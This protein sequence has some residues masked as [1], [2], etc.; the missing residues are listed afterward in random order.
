MGTILD[1]RIEFASTIIGLV[2]Y[3]SGLALTQGQIVEHVPEFEAL[4]TGDDEETIRLRAEE[5]EELFGDLLPSC[6]GER[7]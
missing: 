4:L 2:G 3:K 6:F 7:F 1:R 5:V